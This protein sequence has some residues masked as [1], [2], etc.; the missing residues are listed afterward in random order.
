VV[1]SSCPVHCDVRLL[2]AITFSRINKNRMTVELLTLSKT[3]IQK[4][5]HFLKKPRQLTPLHLLA[6]LGHVVWPYG[7]QELDVVVAVVFCHLLCSGFLL[8]T[9]IDL[10]FP[11]Q[12]IVEKQVVSHPDAVR[13]HGMPLPIVVISDI[14]CKVSWR[15][16]MCS[17]IG[18]FHPKTPN[19]QEGGCSTI[20]NFTV[21][22]GGDHDKNALCAKLQAY[23]PN[24]F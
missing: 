7:S 19:I 15:D 22:A 12:S 23:T 5:F 16:W 3:Q 4:F 10:H 20:F 9:Y 8:K 13:F 6:E 24:N 1:E 14:T 17:P 21:G 11:V 18:L 2:L